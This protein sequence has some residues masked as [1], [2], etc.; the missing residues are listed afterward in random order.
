MTTRNGTSRTGN[1]CKG[2]GT[3]IAPVIY[4]Y[5]SHELMEKAQRGEVRLGGCV[6]PFGI[7]RT[8]NDS[9]CGSCRWERI[10]GMNELKDFEAAHHHGVGYGKPFSTA[11]NE[12]AGGLKMSDWIW[13]VFPQILM[14][15][16]EMSR[17]FAI[18]HRETVVA[19]LDHPTLGA[20]YR[21][22]LGL[23]A[24][25]VLDGRGEMSAWEALKRLMGKRI[26]AKKFV[27]SIT[28]FGEISR[29][30]D[31]HGDIV[32]QF[33]S[34]LAAGLRPCKDTQKAVEH[35]DI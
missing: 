15:S 33:N 29:I 1:V 9:Y 6:V 30:D 32:E 16:S 7:E 8:L 24:R 11:R 26:D 23:V 10:F 12:L 20:N 19:F 35:G 28:L 27:S 31:R 22:A 34:F 14:G 3:P 25:H 4:G 17:R 2:C 18:S 21:E 5:P 13:Y